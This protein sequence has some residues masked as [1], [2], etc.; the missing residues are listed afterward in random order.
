M[1]NTIKRNVLISAILAI[2]LCVSLIAGATFALFTSESKVNIAVT[3]GR[4]D[5]VASVENRQLRSTLLS[6]NLAETSVTYDE[7]SNTVTLDK[8]VPGDVVSFDIRIHNDSDVSVQYRT[9]IEKI[10]G[11]ELWNGL[12][13]TIGGTAYNGEV[14][15]TD[16]APMAV[17]ADDIIVPVEIT[18]PEAAGNE[19]QGKTC[20]LAYTVEAAQGNADMPLEW[21]GTSTTQPTKDED[22]VFQINTPSDFVF[23][24]K[25]SQNQMNGYVTNDYAFGNFVLNCSIDLNGNTVT[26]FSNA[27]GNFQGSFDGKGHTISNFVIDNTNQSYYGG[28]F[29]YLYGATVKNVIVKNA[30][31]KGNKQVGIIAGCV[32]DHSVVTNCKVYNSSVSAIKK[33]GAV[34][35]YLAVNSTVT[36]CY[37]EKCTVMYSD[38]EG[39]EVI[40]FKNTGCTVSGN[41]FRDVTVIN[42]SVISSDEELS[43][44]LT[45]GGN[46]FLSGNATVD[47]ETVN[48][49]TNIDL[50]GK[51]LKLD[52]N[53]KLSGDADLTISGG[54]ISVDDQLRYIDVR[55]ED[56][57]GG[58]VTFENVTFENT[59]KKYPQYG[60]CTDYIEKIVDLW[61]NSDDSNVEFKFVGCTFINAQ[62]T[63]RGA[64]DTSGKFSAT[65]DNC[66]FNNFGVDAAIDVANYLDGT[67]TIKDCTFNLT[68]TGGQNAVYSFNSK[69]ALIFEGANAVNGTAAVASGEA[70]SVDQ[71]KVTTPAITVYSINA[72]NGS[73]VTGLDNVTVSGIATK[74]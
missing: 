20:I 3:A 22:G 58:V 70:G 18:L 47:G 65:F 46:I 43:S 45:S 23:A 17:G 5:V 57:T 7:A 6:G 14:K 1:N 40:G 4:V 42:G 31:V 50:A 38:E 74:D 49:D 66:T 69:V 36:D 48:T 55:P 11:D 39:A 37:A 28:L 33:V 24:M 56:S 10:S 63:F 62:V 44:A 72:T 52:G 25:A 16:W 12:E 26:G 73:T 54:T 13:V 27:G 68:A 41:T 29:G 59:Y 19:Y 64:S 51:T 8:I 9:I 32:S 61:I 35:G 53:I 30:E 21:D 71:I 60:P 34:V 2:T 67:I 15:K